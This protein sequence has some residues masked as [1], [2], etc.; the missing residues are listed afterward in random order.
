MFDNIVTN[1]TFRNN[2]L[3]IYQMER[4]M[5]TP[6]KVYIRPTIQ[7]LLIYYKMCLVA[8]AGDERVVTALGVLLKAESV[9][10]RSSE[11]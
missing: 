1:Y 10:V 5:N 8:E 4:L 3:I 2:P 9:G 6:C 7:A 11:T